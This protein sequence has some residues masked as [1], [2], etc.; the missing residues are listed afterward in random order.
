[1]CVGTNGLEK[2]NRG[3]GRVK[4]AEPHHLPVGWRRGQAGS[5]S[6][7]GMCYRTGTCISFGETR[8]NTLWLEHTVCCPEADELGERKCCLEIVGP[9]N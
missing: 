8:M 2:G 9:E 5:R 6:V 4:G 3:R 7:E 1:M